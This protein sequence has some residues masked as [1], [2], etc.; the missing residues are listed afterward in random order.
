MLGNVHIDFGR[1]NAAVAEQVLD[2]ANIGSGFQQIRSVA[3][4]EHV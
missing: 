1:F 3:V 4:A 2:D